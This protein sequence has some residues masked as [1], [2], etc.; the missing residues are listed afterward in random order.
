M[1]VRLTSL[2]TA[3]AVLFAWLSAVAAADHHEIRIAEVYPGSDSSPDVEYVQLEMTSSGQNFFG[4]TE[5]VVRLFKADG[6]SESVTLNVDVANG[7]RGRRVLVG[8]D[9][10]T[11]DATPDFAFSNGNFLSRSAGA[12]CF[13]SGVFGA[14]DCVSWGAY[15][16]GPLPSSTGGHAF[17]SGLTDGAALGRRTP[18]CGPGLI[19]TNGPGDWLEAT[20]D[21]FNNSAPAATGDPC[22]NTAITKKPKAR[23]TK[24]RARFVFTATQGVNEFKC[25]LDS[26]PF[27]DCTSPFAKRVKVGKHVFKVRADGDPSPASYSWKVVKRR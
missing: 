11:L 4:E 5:S 12:A 8:S 9:L 15:T 21:P 25:K 27:K 7:Q 19:D 26:A 23:T 20:P 14:I 1:G 22:P 6:A 2:A 17:P 24:R 13:V 10:T 3:T 18:G 16:G